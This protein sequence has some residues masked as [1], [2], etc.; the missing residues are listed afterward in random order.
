[1]LLLASAAAGAFLGAGGVPPLNVVAGLILSGALAAG[2]ASAINQYLERRSDGKMK[3]TGKRPLVGSTEAAAQG[4]LWAASAMIALA[5]LGTLPFNPPMAF[6]LLLGALIY[7]GVYTVW[8]KPRSV[9]NI[10]IG[11]AAGSCAVMTGG[12]AVGAASDPG[13]IAL[14]LIV[15]L[16]TPAHF[17]ALALYYRDDYAAGGVPMLPVTLTGRQ[18]AWWIMAHAAAT[19]IASLALAAHPAL[20]L[21]YLIPA[22]FFS[23]LMLV[24]GVRLLIDPGPRRAIR[25]FLL[26][27]VFLLFVFVAVVGAASFNAVW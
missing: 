19:V 15:F 1:M 4:A 21:A 26:T 22:A 9:T 11:G 6:Y 16:W 10:V 3:R 18:T 12:A 27:N 17:W 7:V 5:V 24:G 23:L 13:V 25:F 8:L 14:A 20:G 2:G